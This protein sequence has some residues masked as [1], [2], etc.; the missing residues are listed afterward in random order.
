MIA[1]RLAGF[2][3]NLLFV[4]TADPAINVGRVRSRVLNGGH[5][6]PEDRIVQ[7]YYRTL[8]LAPSAIKA[9]NF[10]DIFDNSAQ[11]QM[12][13]IASV[14]DGFLSS[15]VEPLPDWFAPIA[16]QLRKPDIA[17]V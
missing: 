8:A 10:A 17:G 16:D 12:V 14:S 5:A 11:G 13:L 3:V 7:R 6:V 9:S 4:A 15:M 1:A 2:T